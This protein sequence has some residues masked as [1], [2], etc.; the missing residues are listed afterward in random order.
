MEDISKWSKLKQFGIKRSENPIMLY[1]LALFDLAGNLLCFSL[2]QQA[3]CLTSQVHLRDVSKVPGKD[4][5]KRLSTV[6]S[7]VFCKLHSKLPQVQTWGTQCS[8]SCLEA[9]EGSNEKT[10]NYVQCQRSIGNLWTLIVTLKMSCGWRFDAMM[11]F[12]TLMI[13]LKFLGGGMLISFWHVPPYHVIVLARGLHQFDR[14][15]I[16]NDMCCVSQKKAVN[17]IRSARALQQF[18]QIC[19][20]FT[21]QKNPKK[22]LDEISSACNSLPIAIFFWT[23][24]SVWLSRN[25]STSP[26]LDWATTLQAWHRCASTNIKWAPWQACVL[27]IQVFIILTVDLHRFKVGCL[28]SRNGEARQRAMASWTCKDASLAWDGKS[29][30]IVRHVN[31]ITLDCT[32]PHVTSRDI[33]S[34]ARLK[35]KACVSLPKAPFPLCLL[36]HQATGS[37]TMTSS[38]GCRW[39]QA[40]HQ[41]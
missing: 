6:D 2:L 12:W 28:A 8:R 25:H 27:L 24:S 23:Q 22:T 17:E 38:D 32:G 4:D 40:L 31:N 33:E 1:A 29:V 26:R 19:S 10:G 5:E 3:A 18:E 15:L 9:P 21:H 20:A 11:F 14:I 7:V 13:T 30:Q 34:S 37:E 16:K 36:G 39:M 41:I 35:F